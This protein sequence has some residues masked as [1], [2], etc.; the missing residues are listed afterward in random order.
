MAFTLD[1]D[2]L[3]HIVH[4]LNNVSEGLKHGHLVVFLDGDPDAPAV[5][6]K[7]METCDALLGLIEM[8]VLEQVLES[9]P[10]EAQ[11]NIRVDL[12]N[13]VMFPGVT[14]EA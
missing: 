2:T 10:E 8:S 7:L 3:S 11:N 13:V 12:D 6:Q 9:L 5:E 14:Q 4:L 1:A